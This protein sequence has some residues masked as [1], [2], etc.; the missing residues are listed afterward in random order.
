MPGMRQHRSK[1]KIDQVPRKPPQAQAAA[2]VDH[3]TSRQQET[4]MDM[5]STTRASRMVAVLFSAT[6]MAACGGGGSSPAPAAPT[7]SPAPGPAPSPN[8]AAF[9]TP[10]DTSTTAQAGGIETY[11]YAENGAAQTAG[12][13]AFAASAVSYSAALSSAQGFAGAALRLYAPNNTA[14]N[15]SAYSRLRIQL[16][17][18]TD[19]LLW[20]KLQPSP[21]SGDGC[22]ATAQAVVSA[23]LGEVVIDLDSA[24]FPLPAHCAT[25]TTL[26]TVRA[27]L[28]AVDVI[29]PAATAGTHDLAVGAISLVP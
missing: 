6:L 19:A 11:Q 3:G 27:G 29:N 5:I 2:G 21:I 25:G 23:T 14:F 20:V 15:A 13:P 8:D 28:L 26:N 7:P 1:R 22:T 17:S 16:R 18:S 12:A 24:H 9:A 4:T 10:T